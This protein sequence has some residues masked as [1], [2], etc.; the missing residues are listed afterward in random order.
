MEATYTEK[1][2]IIGPNGQPSPQ[3][4]YLDSYIW[5]E[6]PF[7]PLLHTTP[8]TSVLRSIRKELER[9]G[10]IKNQTFFF[11][12]TNCQKCVA[13]TAFLFQ[14]DPGTDPETDEEK[15]SERAPNKKFAV[16][17]QILDKIPTISRANSKTSFDFGEGV[18]YFLCD[19]DGTVQEFYDEN[20]PKEYA[21]NKHKLWE[22]KEFWESEE[23]KR[24]LRM[25]MDKL[26]GCNLK[27]KNLVRALEWNPPEEMIPANQRI[28]IRP[29]SARAHRT[30]S[31]AS[32]P[33][34]IAEDPTHPKHNLQITKNALALS[35]HFC[36]FLDDNKVSTPPLS[37]S[38][39]TCSE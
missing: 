30:R 38:I 10:F 2:D 28:K 1:V 17:S 25:G 11:S 16:Y 5:A 7:T 27:W 35:T 24:L 15:E 23:K 18:H 20:I 19:D 12:A 37:F 21:I 26:N 14:V 31:V 36:Q 4:T 8:I 22:K 3:R 32:Q 39:P 33:L 6:N 9:G 34:T 29:R 13:A